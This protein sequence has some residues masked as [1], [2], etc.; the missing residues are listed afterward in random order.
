MVDRTHPWQQ[1]GTA[2]KVAIA[3]TLYFQ[4]NR[5]CCQTLHF[6][7]KP[8][9]MP[10]CF[11]SSSWTSLAE[12]PKRQATK[13]W[14]RV[15]F[16]LNPTGPSGVANEIMKDLLSASTCLIRKVVSTLR[17]HLHSSYYV[18]CMLR[19]FASGTNP[20]AWAWCVYSFL[21]FSQCC[22]DSTPSKLMHHIEPIVTPTHPS[23]GVW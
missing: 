5:F 8:S 21:G 12:Q 20:L 18:I 11:F 13:V 16:S 15:Y 6:T 22:W 1:Q 2:Q 10:L 9:A 23:H 4:N 7:N 14:W 17:V 19:W 3:V